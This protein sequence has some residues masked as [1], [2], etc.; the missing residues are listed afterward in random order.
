MNLDDLY[1]VHPS[2]DQ[3]SQQR[4]EELPQQAAQAGK[5]AHPVGVAPKKLA[6]NQCHIRPPPQTLDHQIEQPLGGPYTNIAFVPEIDI[7]TIEGRLTV[8]THDTVE[9]PSVTQENII[10]HQTNIGGVVQDSGEQEK[11][12]P[13]GSQE[14]G[15]AD[16]V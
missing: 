5:N 2:A 12:E 11:P 1:G 6:E 16:F 8:P 14:T 9:P 13:T 7:T 15:R 10:Q 4:S 3:Q